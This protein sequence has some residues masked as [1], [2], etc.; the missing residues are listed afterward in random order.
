MCTK[1]PLLGYWWVCPYMN[2]SL[3]SV[4]DIAYAPATSPE[5]K[6]S[7]EYLHP[8]YHFFYL[9]P[10]G[11]CYKSL[12]ARTTKLMNSFFSMTIQSLRKLTK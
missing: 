5:L 7:Y 12:K 6:P 10:P 1:L 2:C 3:S 8:A 4:K 11:R 9:L